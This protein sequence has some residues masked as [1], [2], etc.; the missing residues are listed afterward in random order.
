[1]AHEFTPTNT[2]EVM[3]QQAMAGKASMPEFLSVLVKS[4]I[5]MPCVN[6][7]QIDATNFVPLIF[8]RE[9]QSMAVAFTNLSLLNIYK[10]HIKGNIAMNAGQLLSRLA[11]GYGVVIN[12]GYTLGLE[13]QEHG[14]KSIV[15]QFV[16]ESVNT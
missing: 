11:P 6:E 7:L 10:D 2:L 12:P 8:D 1:M 13:I 3:L 4:D 14:I 5:Y 16:A 9:G 15:A